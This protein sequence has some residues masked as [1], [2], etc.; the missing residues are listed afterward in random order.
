MDIL[1]DRLHRDVRRSSARPDPTRMTGMIRSYPR[2]IFVIAKLL[3]R[4]P[5]RHGP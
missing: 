1:K 2:T 5:I 4:C 3:D